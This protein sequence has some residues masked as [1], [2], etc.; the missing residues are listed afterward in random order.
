MAIKSRVVLPYLIP[1]LSAPP[2]N[3][4][5]LA[6]LASVAGEALTRFLNRI[7]PAL[8]TALSDS[9]G[10]PDEVQQLEYCQTVVL[11]VTD[12]AGTRTIV[13]QLLEHTRADCPLRR[14]S[15]A[16]LLCA[17]CGSSKADFSAYIPQLMR[18]LIHLCTDD[19]KEVLQMAWEALNAVTKTIDPKQQALYV[20][21]VRQAVRYA[22]SDIKCSDGLIPGFC[23]PKGIMPILPI[24][25]E[26]ILNGDG[27]EKE[28]AAQGLGE[29]IKVTSASALQ[30][31]VVTIT[32]PLIRILGDRF[33]WQVK[34]AVLET[35]AILLAKVGVMLKQFL[36]QLQTTF[37]KAL[38][39]PTRQVRLRA[40][41]AL[42]QLIVIHA[43]CDPLF[44]DLHTGIKNADDTQ[45]RETMLQ[46]LRGVITA[47]G[48]KMS[49]TMRKQIHTTLAGMLSHP[50]DVTRS[51]AAGCFGA[52][53]RVLPPEQLADTLNNYILADDLAADEWQLRHGRTAA[54]AVAIKEGAGV[55]YVPQYEQP[56]IKCLLTRLTADKVPIAGSAIRASGYLIQYLM[57]AEQA[58]PQTL[59]VPF[60]RVSKIDKKVVF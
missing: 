50:E 49:D 3:T 5:A 21:D 15:A 12:D 47:A 46:A 29:V 44:A 23:L 33:S 9:H 13:D 6:I 37:L 27:D 22:I 35:L 38:N 48:D 51:A 45:V 20:G 14:R 25:R 53:T 34:A 36:P 28:G 4:K 10:T 30:P 39:D 42:G 41:H 56:I 7:L 24:F 40:A 17:F 54:L 57:L 18:G 1:Q 11:S 32:G 52:L 19:D 2:V 55:V 60:V 16:A 31:S 43:R 8:L 58:L 59:L 26:A